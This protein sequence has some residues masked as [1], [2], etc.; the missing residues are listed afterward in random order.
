MAVANIEHMFDRDV[1]VWDL[2]LDDVDC[3]WELTMRAM[4]A[5]PEPHPGAVPPL[6]EEL[7][8]SGALAILLSIADLDRV[9]SEEKIRALRAHARLV[10]H[11]QAR[12]FDAIMAICD[13]YRA[14]LSESETDL[15]M[16]G[17]GAE[18]RAALRLTRRSAE[19]ELGLAYQLR[20]RQPRVLEALRD[21]RTDLRRARVLI[22][23]TQVTSS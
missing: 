1:G 11:H 14:L 6:A 23:E 8:P 4:E 18:L 17:T 5:P 9:G 2:D 19:F 7:P 21:G 10:S 20:E 13:D 16:E 15:V 22:G 12:M 3:Q